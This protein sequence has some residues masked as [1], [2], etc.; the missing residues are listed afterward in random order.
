MIMWAMSD[1]GIPRSL[2][3]M[4]GFGVHTFRLVNAEG[5]S[6][7]AKFHWKPLRGAHSLVWDEALKIAGRK[8]RISTG[9]T[10]G[11]R[12]KR[13]A[14]PEWEFGLQTIP[15]GEETQYDFDILDPTKLWP[16]RPDSDPPRRQNDA[17]SEPRN[18]YFAAEPSRSLSAPPISCRG[19]IS[20]MIRCCKDATF[21][22]KTRSSA[23]WG[24][25]TSR[26]C[27]SIGRW[28]PSRTTSVTA[29][30]ATPSTKAVCPMP[31][32]S[33][34]G[35]SPDEVTPQRPGYVSYPEQVSGPKVRAAQ[36]KLRRPLRAGETVLEQHD[37]TGKRAYRQSPAI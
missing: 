14:I 33:L 30:C 35:H 2:A 21:R 8:T 6:T 9:A 17:Q 4:D 11:K 22:T 13:A 18:N 29:R 7:Y 1:R 25:R 20:P 32:A 5:K 24:R 26:N 3:L 27:R 19:L 15:E 37:S 12:L 36:R 28:L 34:D 23:V 10:C 16:G 31:Q